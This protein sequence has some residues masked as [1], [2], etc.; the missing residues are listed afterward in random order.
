M[1]QFNAYAPPDLWG[2]W[3]TIGSH[4]GSVTFDISYEALGETLVVGR[5][6]YWKGIGPGGQVIEEFRD[7]TTITTSNSG[8]NVEVSFKGIPTGSPVQGMISP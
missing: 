8:A 4:L 2:A 6:R 5:V 7:S 3:V 1:A